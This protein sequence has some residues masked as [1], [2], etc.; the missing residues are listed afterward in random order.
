M[1]THRGDYW[2]V[3][4]TDAWFHFKRFRDGITVLKIGPVWLSWF[5]MLRPRFEFSIKR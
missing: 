5:P 1:I 3:G 2:Y 4:R